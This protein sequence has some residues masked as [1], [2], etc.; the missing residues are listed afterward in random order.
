MTKKKKFAL[1]FG[2]FSLTIDFVFVYIIGKKCC[3]KIN[4]S[5]PFRLTLVFIGKRYAI[6]RP[7]ILPLCSCSNDFKWGS[8][9]E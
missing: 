5:S 9:K 3:V 7:Y 1:S 2:L 4:R 8:V 6:I